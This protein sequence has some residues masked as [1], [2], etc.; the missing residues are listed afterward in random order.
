MKLPAW[1]KDVISEDDLKKGALVHFFLALTRSGT[2]YL[3]HGDK[4]SNG[5]GEMLLDM[6]QDGKLN[7]D[8]GGYAEI[9]ERLR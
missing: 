2:L 3:L 6:V 9:R 4:Y 8:F 5:M 1:A 7:R